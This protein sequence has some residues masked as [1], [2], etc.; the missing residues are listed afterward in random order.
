MPYVLEKNKILILSISQVI[1]DKVGVFYPGLR[2]DLKYLKN[3]DFI[4]KNF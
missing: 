4:C 3:N 1:P 2:N